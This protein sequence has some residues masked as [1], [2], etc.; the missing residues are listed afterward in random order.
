LENLTK[1]SDGDSVEQTANGGTVGKCEIIHKSSALK[2]GKKREIDGN[3][4]CLSICK[5]YK[6]G[7]GG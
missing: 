1:Y 5:G 4:T 2:T 3:L 7:G 6:A